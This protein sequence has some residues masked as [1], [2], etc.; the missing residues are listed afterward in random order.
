MRDVTDIHPAF[1]RLVRVKL[2]IDGVANGVIS[3]KN[4]ESQ[5]RQE[6]RGKQPLAPAEC[7]KG[8]DYTV[9]HI[10]SMLLLAGV[11]KTT[12]RR[13]YLDNE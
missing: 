3:V 8:F 6:R 12:R 4:G 11:T 9:Q 1:D 5:D 2:P 7:L 13:V 10:P